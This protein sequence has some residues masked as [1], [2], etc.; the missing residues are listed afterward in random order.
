MLLFR[1][2]SPH[3]S[4]FSH[5]CTARRTRAVAVPR[6]AMS[7][8]EE[9]NESA[10]SLQAGRDP[11][12]ASPPLSPSGAPSYLGLG[13]TGISYVLLSRGWVNVFEYRVGCT[14]SSTPPETRHA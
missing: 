9:K 8:P 12:I 11:T 13:T 1:L 5:P 2:R 10:A 4:V 14:W 7:A 6:P 3:F